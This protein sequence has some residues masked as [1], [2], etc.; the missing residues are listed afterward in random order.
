MKL[1]IVIISW[2]SLPML[3][4]CMRSLDES[5][6]QPETELV[7]VDNGSTD[8]ASSWMAE[9]YPDAVRIRLDRNYGVAYARNRGVEAA[10][11]D[12]IL[13]IDDDTEPTLK[14]LEAMTDYVRSRPQVGICGVALRDKEGNLQQSFKEYPGLR[15][16]IKNVFKSLLGIKEKVVAPKGPTEIC[17]VIGACQLIRREVF[18]KIGL[19]DESIFYGPEDADFCIRARSAGYKTV[20]LP[21]VRILHHW[22]RATSRRILSPLGRKHFRAL[23]HFYRKHNKWL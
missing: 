7:W 23:L 17:Y 16:K 8:G 4:A 5:L 3:K 1:S 19:L 13:F 11:G 6:A 15:V 12:Y 21:S 20:Y 10:T 9:H 14:A 2:N 18:D 22:R